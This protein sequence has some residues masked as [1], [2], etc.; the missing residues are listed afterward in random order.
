MHVLDTGCFVSAELAQQPSEQK[1]SVCT[2]ASFP[3]LSQAEP[4]GSYP[5]PHHTHQAHP[6]LSTGGNSAGGGIEPESKKEVQGNNQSCSTQGGPILPVLWG[7]CD[8]S[9]VPTV[10]YAHPSVPKREK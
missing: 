6:W 10:R 8:Y 5:A 2:A 1:P 4:P 3:L 9:T 7:M